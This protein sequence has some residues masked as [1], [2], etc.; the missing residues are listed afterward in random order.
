MIGLTVR[1]GTYSANPSTVVTFR[2]ASI[3]PLSEVIDRG[4]SWRFS[5]RFCAVTITSS[6]PPWSGL[7]CCCGASCDHAPGAYAVLQSKVAV[8]TAFTFSIG[9]SSVK[10]LS[11]QVPRG[12]VSEGHGRSECSA[13]SR[14]EMPHNAGGGVS[15]RVEARDWRCVLIERLREFVR[16]DPPI[17]TYIARIDRHREERSRSERRKIG[18]RRDLGI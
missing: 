16:P 12:D 2:S 7:A 6:S 1:F 8:T 5:A 9:A 4:T 14:V 10:T 11:Y 13:S 17:C 3:S 15:Y 18:I